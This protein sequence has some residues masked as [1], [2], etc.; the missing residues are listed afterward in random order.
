MI[1]SQTGFDLF[2]RGIFDSL[3]L[4]MVIPFSI[5]TFIGYHLLILKR[6]KAAIISFAFSLLIGIVYLLMAG[7]L[8]TLIIFAYVSLFYFI[9]FVP[10]WLL[11]KII[12]WYE[13]KFIYDKYHRKIRE[14]REN[15]S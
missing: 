12:A 8:P 7:L 3:L 1:E 4:F 6:T 14:S 9:I 5:P 10:F 11:D 2:K 15:K 13:K